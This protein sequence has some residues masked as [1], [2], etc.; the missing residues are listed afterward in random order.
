MVEGEPQPCKL[1]SLLTST[2]FSFGHSFGDP[3]PLSAPAGTIRQPRLDSSGS[4]S[5]EVLLTRPLNS[6]YCLPPL[7]PGEHSG[8]GKSHQNNPH[9]VLFRKEQE[10]IDAA[11]RAI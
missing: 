3:I 6:A 5:S 10:P 1:E 11:V 2:I 4:P 7:Y 8:E 9:S